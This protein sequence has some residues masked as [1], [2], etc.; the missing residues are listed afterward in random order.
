M[1]RFLK[2]LD[3]LLNQATATE[4]AFASAWNTVP[5]ASVKASNDHIVS[6]IETPVRHTRKA[7]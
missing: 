4:A 6:R 3:T 5:E 2:T 7:A 1:S